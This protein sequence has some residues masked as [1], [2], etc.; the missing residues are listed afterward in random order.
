MRALNTPVL[1][2]VAANSRTDDT[3]DVTRRAGELLPRAE[4]DV[5]PGVSHHALPQSAPPE[6]ARRLSEFLGEPLE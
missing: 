5:V 3:Y 1:L 4:I 6:L 2:L